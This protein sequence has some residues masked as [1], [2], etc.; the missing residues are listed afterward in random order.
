MSRPL[1]ILARLPTHLEATRPGKLLGEVT[2]ALARDLDVL[3]AQ[4]AGVRR[5]HRLGEADEFADLHALAA[6]HGIRQGELAMLAL[7]FDRVAAAFASLRAATDR[8]A[9]LAAAEDVLSVWGLDVPAPLLAAFAM[10][11]APDLAGAAGADALARLGAAITASLRHAERIG[12]ARARVMRIC[13]RH[14]EGN[15]TVSAL[16]DGAAIALDL[17]LG[18]V[19]HSADRFLHAAFARDRLRLTPPPLPAPT[20][21]ARP[22]ILPPLP[23]AAEVL[24]LVENPLRRT[25][26]DPAERHSGELFDLLRRGFERSLLQLRVTGAGETAPRTLGPMLVNRDEGHGIGFAGEVPPGATLVFDEEGRVTLDGADVTSFAFAFRGAVFAEA[27]HESPHDFRFDDEATRFAEATPAGALD[28]EFSFP[29]AGEAISVP[30]VAVGV[31]RFAFFVRDAHFAAGDPAGEVL[32]ATP[33]PFQ[34]VFD[35]SVFV[36]GAGETPPVAALVA[37]SWMEHEAYKLRLVIPARFRGFGD[38]PEG[39]EVRRR[40]AQAVDRFRPAGVAL[41]VAFIDERWVLGEGTLGTTETSAV[42][43]LAGGVALWPAP[44]DSG[45]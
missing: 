22:I 1:T 29:H 27:G 15:G 20:P 10:G 35:E 43:A 17:D 40:V 12:A 30:G 39:T 19:E 38:D 42:A 5:A 9:A 8:A 28:R 24:G 16:M 2:A 14:A 33:H 44:P 7:R 23:P 4:L 32:E 11:P 34:G 21:D 37:L 26:T 31:T 36:A 45:G 3:A 18:P 6:L 41:E 13:R 25:G